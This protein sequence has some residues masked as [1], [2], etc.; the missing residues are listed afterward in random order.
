MGGAFMMIAL[1]PDEEWKNYL[2][3]DEDLT[4]DDE[5]LE[6]ELSEE[7]DDEYDDVLRLAVPNIA[8]KLVR[9]HPKRHCTRTH[10]GS[11]RTLPE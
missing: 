1:V 6:E 10:L 4:I 7:L 9:Q 5:T 2:E 11:N 8:D 3:D